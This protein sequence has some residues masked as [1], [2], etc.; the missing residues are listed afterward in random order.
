MVA[1]ARRQRATAPLEPT[2]PSRAAELLALLD[3]NPGASTEA[4][5]RRLVL[6]KEFTVLEAQRFLHIRHPPARVLN[7]RQDGHSIADRWVRQTSERGHEHRTKLYTLLGLEG[8][9]D[10]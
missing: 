3:T 8:Q 5:C 2:T 1:T 4:Q 7:L 6:A 9:V 10:A